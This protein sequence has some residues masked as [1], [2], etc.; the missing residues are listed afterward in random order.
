ML[1][2]AREQARERGFDTLSLLVFEQ[3]ERAVGLYKHN[4]FKVVDRAQVVPHNLIYHTG[5]V[6][7]MASG[8]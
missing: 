7:L 6:L 2:I 3:N 5:D 8:I 1:S 4:G